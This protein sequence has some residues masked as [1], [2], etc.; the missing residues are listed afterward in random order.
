M[1]GGYTNGQNVPQ[2]NTLTINWS[3]GTAVSTGQF[4]IWVVDGSGN[5]LLGQQKNAVAGTTAY[6]T[7]RTLSVPAG[8]GYK[9]RVSYRATSGQ[10][11][12]VT[13]FATGTFNVI[14]LPTVTVTAPAD[15]ASYAVGS[16]LPVT[17]TL[18]TAVASGQF[19]VWVVDSGGSLLL[20]QTVN[21]VAGSTSYSTKRTLNVPA[22]SGYRVRVS[23]RTSS[24]SSWGVTSYSPGTFTV[25]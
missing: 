15:G 8:T 10:Q 23:Y 1:T 2:Y 3:V 9:V 22:G 12:S 17:W 6:T 14:S 16:V 21:V 24:G 25:N 19:G 7:T 5:L 20:A 18:S 13:S 11:W 4:G